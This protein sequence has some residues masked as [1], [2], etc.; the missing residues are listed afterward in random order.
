[1]H[2]CWLL[3]A[4]QTANGPG[5]RLHAD[6][7]QQTHLVQAVNLADSTRTNLALHE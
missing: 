2:P 7:M 4:Q 1:M 5:S 3:T 6:Y